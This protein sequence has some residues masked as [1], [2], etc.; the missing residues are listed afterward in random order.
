MNFTDK[1]ININNQTSITGSG[2]GRPRPRD[3]VGQHAVELAAVPER[4]GSQEPAQRRRSRHAVSEHRGG[5]TRPQ[6]VAVLDAV[7]AQRHRR[8]HRHHLAPRIRA[9]GTLA[10]THRLIDELLDPRTLREQPRQHHTGVGDR[11]LIIKHHDRLLVHHVGDLLSGAA[12][13][14]ICRYQALLGRSLHPITG[15]KRWIEAKR[16]ERQLEPDALHRLRSLGD[17]RR[18]AA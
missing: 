10:Q 8:Q 4:E 16:A 12:T 13:G 6:D 3:A 1:R 14:A 11:P 17:G 15:T 2:A 5:L 18:L 7:R 9:A